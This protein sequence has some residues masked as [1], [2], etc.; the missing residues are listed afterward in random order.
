[1]STRAPVYGFQTDS[2]R[3]LVIDQRRICLL[4]AFKSIRLAF[5]SARFLISALIFSIKLLVSA[6]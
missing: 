2:D 6:S 3:D 5:A 4:G 1:M